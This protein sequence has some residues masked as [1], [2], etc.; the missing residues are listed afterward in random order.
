LVNLKHCIDCLDEQQS[1]IMWWTANDGRPD[2]IGKYR[3]ITKFIVD[4]MRIGE[5]H[6]FRLFGWDIAIIVSHVM[7]VAF[8]EHQVTGVHFLPVSS[9]NCQD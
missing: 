3:M 9:D 8:E 6:M 4:P 2:K 7:K 1:E 5:R